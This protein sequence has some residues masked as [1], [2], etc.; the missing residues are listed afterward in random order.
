MSGGIQGPFSNVLLSAIVAF[1]PLLWLLISLGW[2]KMKAYI[3]AL[4]SLALAILLSITTWGMP[5]KFASQSVLEGVA[6]GLWPIVWVI[7][8]AIYTYNVT[9]ETGC[10]NIINETLAKISPDRRIQALILAFSFGGFLEAAAGFGTAVAIPA[11]LLAGIGFDPLFAAVICLIANTVPVAFGGIGIPIITLSQ[12]TGIEE[13]LLTTYTAYQLIP[14]I[15]ILPIVLVIIMT[16]SFKYL[17]EVLGA[18]IVSGISFA[19]FQTAVAV[20]VGP[21]VAAI[22][23]SLASL[24]SII[25]YVKIKPV[26][27]IW[28]FPDEKASGEIAS[29]NAV[30]EHDKRISGK[31]QLIAWTPYI[32][33][34]VLIMAVNLIPDLKF[35]GDVATKVQ[36]Y[37]GPNGKPS[38][39]QWIT[40]PGTIMFISAIIGGFVQG[41]SIKGLLKIFGK[42]IKQLLPTIVVVSSIVA[43]A[44]VMGYSGMISVIA[45]ALADT[46]GKVY[47]FISPLIGALGT[48]IT[49][50]DTSSNILFGALQKQT[51]L[52][53][54]ANA[55]WIAAANTVGASAGKMISPQSIAVAASATGLVGKEGRILNSTLIYCIGY[56]ILL[57]IVVFTFGYIV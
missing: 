29:T 12:V 14:F 15:I 50:S 44:K 4:I 39:F 9:V 56:A 28:L 54:H 11:S 52:Q 46:T 49:G 57:G 2:F 30:N 19:L 33:L 37:F 53:I 36:I 48:F 22:V 42:T 35:L 3:A 21:E 26:K 25:I 45:V 8:A 10:M 47:P 1:I 18:C 51:A 41:S 24:L 16:K 20:F 32:V 55:A 6:T 23:G 27:K 31:K 7:I 13:S 40:T 17:K 43:M 34:F 5:V 38:S